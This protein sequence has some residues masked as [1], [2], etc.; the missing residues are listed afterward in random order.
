MHGQGVFPP[1]PRD[2][3]FPGFNPGHYPA[4]DEHF[5][6][7]GMEHARFG[8]DPRYADNAHYR[9][10]THTYPPVG[11][12]HVPLGMGSSESLHMTNF[13]SPEMHLLPMQSDDMAFDRDMRQEPVIPGQT[14]IQLPSAPPPQSYDN[15]GHGNAST[16]HLR[17]G[18]DAYIPTSDDDIRRI[19]G[20]G[21]DQELSLNALADPPPGQR[22]GQAIPTLSQLAI[23]GSPL[24]RL[25]LQEIYQALEDRFEWFRNNRDDK[26]WQVGIHCR[27]LWIRHILTH[28]PTQNS[29]RH[30]LSLYKCFRRIAKPITEPGKGSY[31]VVDYSA[32]PGTK[33]PRKRNKRPTKAELRAMKEKE[34]QEVQG[35]QGSQEAQE[36]GDSSPDGEEDDQGFPS[37]AQSTQ[38]MVIDPSLQSVGH[39]VG[40]SRTSRNS[41]RSIARRGNSPYAQATQLSGQGQSRRPTAP[42]PFPTLSQMGSRNP[43][44]TFGQP[45]FGQPSLFPTSMPSMYGQAQMRA[46]SGWYPGVNQG[47]QSFLPPPQPR[48][49]GG[50]IGIGSAPPDAAHTAHRAAPARAHTLPMPVNMGHGA[51][52]A[53]LPPLPGVDQLRDPGGRFVAR[54]TVAAMQ[55]QATGGHG[56]EFVQGS[57]RAGRRTS[58]SSNSSR[59]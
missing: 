14:R 11:A 29:I 33:R 21:P 39:L 50:G 16:S 41:A 5:R 57:S 47:G 44:A 19:L 20:L 52:Y 9:P 38:D 22:P 45:S 25:T 24:K 59:E 34:E 54:G 15:H 31:W 23:L 53:Q 26:S 48:S 18:D 30:N 28:V 2:F 17:V 27:S 40:Q 46:P 49:M 13:P 12:P 58:S 1:R 7:V 43:S 36:E 51:S 6:R 32:G 8:T 56:P 35:A 4:Y 37:P 55:M 3:P 42:P 10:R